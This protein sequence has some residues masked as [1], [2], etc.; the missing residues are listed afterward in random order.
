MLSAIWLK[1]KASFPT[2]SVAKTSA[3]AV[4]FPKENSCAV[5]CNLSIGLGIARLKTIAQ[6]VIK[7]IASS[8]TANSC[9]KL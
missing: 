2:S 8:S 9:H 5:C 3:L 4:R 6:A 1:V 7:I